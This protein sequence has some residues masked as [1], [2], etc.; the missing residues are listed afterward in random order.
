MRGLR[1]VAQ[2]GSGD[3]E[4]EGRR[5]LLVR[6]SGEQARQAARDL[7]DGAGGRGRQG[8]CRYRAA[9]RKG[10][11]PDRWRQL[12][13]RRRYPTC[14]CACGQRD[15]LC[16]C[17]DERRRLGPGARL[18]HDDRRT[19][20]RGEASRSD[21]QDT[22]AW[23]GRH[24]A[25]ARP[26]EA[27]RHRRARLFALWRKRRRPFRQNGP[28]RH[29]IRD[30]GRLCG[31]HERIAPCQCRRAAA[32]GRRR[33]HAAARPRPLS[34]RSRPA[35]HRGSVA[36]GQRDRIVAARPHRLR[37]GEGSRAR[38]VRGP[39]FRFGRRALDDQGGDRRGGAGT[40]AVERALCTLPVSYTHLDVYKRQG[41]GSRAREVRGPRFRFG[42]RALDDQGGDRRGGAGTGAV[43]RALCTLQLARRSHLWRQAPVRHA[44]RVR[45]PP[46]KN[47]GLRSEVRA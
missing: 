41:E 5:G 1:H 13:L 21:L 15:Q 27:Q 6:R 24:P 10:R 30:H 8:H 35:R 45:R 16:R 38:E 29:R 36:A 20:R 46:G 40:G 11:H 17:R 14:Q 31:R 22:G 12:L 4:G 26:R 44:L 3:G 28:Q 43:E 39:R 7:A 33:D 18:L 2:S 42:R 34:L 25:H 9:P 37:A 47:C 23:H 32:C 19:G